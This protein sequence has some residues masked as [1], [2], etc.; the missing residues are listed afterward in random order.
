MKKLVLTLAASLMILV[1]VH[2]QAQPDTITRSLV[3]SMGGFNEVPGLSLSYSVGEVAI[4]TFV[5]GGGNNLLTQGFQQENLYPVNLDDEIIAYMDLNFWPNPASTTLNI[6]VSTD[7][8]LQMNVG[9]YDL[10]GRPTGIPTVDLMVQAPVE[11]SFDLD[12]LAEGSY[13]L[14]FKSEQGETMQS[15]KIQKIN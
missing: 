13:F 11:A 8:L 10:L 5:S 4:Q 3:S 1:Q 14:I 9:I 12:R 2:A 15:V 7:R 6:K